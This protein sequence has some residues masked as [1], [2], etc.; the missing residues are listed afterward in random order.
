MNKAKALVADLE[1]V[2]TIAVCWQEELLDEFNQRHT[3]KVSVLKATS[4]ENV[5]I[6]INDFKVARVENVMMPVEKK[7]ILARFE[8]HVGDLQAL[9]SYNVERKVTLRN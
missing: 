5:D 3:M 8:E 1:S 7:L 4:A 9:G 6:L 2:E